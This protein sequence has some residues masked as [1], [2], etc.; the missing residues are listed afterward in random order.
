MAGH[1]NFG[2]LRKKMSPQQN[3]AVA[4]RVRELREEMLLCELRKH[5][6]L[7]Q[8]QLAEILG[9]S[10]PTLSAQEKQTDMEI[11]TLR[12][13][14]EAMGGELEIR[15]IMPNGTIPLKQFSDSK[16]TQNQH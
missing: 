7:T 11:G 6:N 5:S 14:V 4:K 15:A 2:T 3:K 10:Q 8:V 9:I 16:P 12:R 1:K 13:L